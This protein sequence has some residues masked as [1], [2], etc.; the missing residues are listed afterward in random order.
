M[1]FARVVEL[2]DTQDLGSCAARC[3]GSSPPSRTT[4]PLHLQGFARSAPHL[5]ANLYANYP[6]NFMEIDSP[7]YKVSSPERCE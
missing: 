5:Y 2:V 4:Q 1:Y 3:G 6:Y 7:V